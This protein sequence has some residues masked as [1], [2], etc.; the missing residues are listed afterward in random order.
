MYIF[1]CLFVVSVCKSRFLTR[2]YYAS[3]QF[4]LHHWLS[5]QHDGNKEFSQSVTSPIITRR[6]PCFSDV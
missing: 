1:F 4:T 5:F 3:Q 2:V 6:I